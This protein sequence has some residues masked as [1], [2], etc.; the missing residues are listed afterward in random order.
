MTPEERTAE[1]IRF[2]AEGCRELGSDMYGAL[3]DE[4]AADLVAGG[5]THRVLAGY[6]DVRRRD[7]LA[8]RLMAGVH[9]VVLSGAAPE[10]A[11]HYP[12][13]GGDWQASRDALWPAFVDVLFTHEATIR[14]WL[15]AAPQTNEVGRAA[16]L[17]G[18]L[19]YL[20]ADAPLEMRLTEIGASAGLNLRAD[21][22]RIS[23]A[24]A[25]SGP[26]SSPLVLTDAWLGTSPPPA[27]V[28]VVDRIGFDL[29]PVDPTTAAGRVRLCAYVWADQL[30][31]MLRLRAAI[32]VAAQVPA[33]LVAGDAVE[34]VPRLEPSSGRWTVLWHSVFQQYLSADQYAVLMAAV[35]RIGD[36][37]TPDAPFAYLT[38]EPEPAA[39]SPAVPVVLTTWPGARRRVLGYAATAHGL[40]VTWTC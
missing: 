16:A 6:L 31:R 21:R 2:Q 17:A 15:G 39:T 36:A 1:H 37:A 40:P 34:A 10:L 27:E 19:R 32:D 25:S 13:A 14:E 33:T 26:A 5:P 28:R 23:G 7:A 8:L 35:H 11:R 3:L 18:G 12:S 9:A 38:L 22:F 24:V 20:A 4:C 30:N 29:A